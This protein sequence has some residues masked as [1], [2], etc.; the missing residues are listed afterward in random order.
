MILSALLMDNRITVRYNLKGGDYFSGSSIFKQR[1]Y[2]LV[3]SLT[4]VHSSIAPACIRI[5]ISLIR[6]LNT[7]IMV[8]N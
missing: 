8:L 6:V 3:S 1:S 7:S 4:P 5:C 2:F